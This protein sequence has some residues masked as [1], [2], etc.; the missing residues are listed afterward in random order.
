MQAGVLVNYSTCPTP[1]CE[2]RSFKKKKKWLLSL[3]IKYCCDTCNKTQ[4]IQATSCPCTQ[5]NYSTKRHTHRLIMNI[6]SECSAFQIYGLFVLQHQKKASNRYKFI[7]Q[8]ENK[9]AVTKTTGS[10]AT[11][12]LAPTEH[13]SQH[14]GVWNYMKTRRQ[15]K[16]TEAL[17]YALQDDERLTCQAP[18]KIQQILIYVLVHVEWIQLINTY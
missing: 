2:N 4:M 10:P 8:Q 1:K 5:T 15:T 16:P 17:T 9:L 7:L 13:W 14:H 3:S 12:G 18:W 11:D 6:Y